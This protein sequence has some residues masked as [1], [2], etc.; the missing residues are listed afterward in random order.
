MT[1]PVPPE[2]PLLERLRGAVLALCAP[3][4]DGRRTGAAGGAAACDLLETELAR[5]GLEPAGEQGYRQRVPGCGG[6]NLL[7]R[8]PGSGPLSE[9]AVLVG[10]HYDHLGS[11]G[12]DVYHGADDNA[13]AVAITL[14]LGRALRARPPAGR[15]V[16]LALFD[17]EEPPHFTSQSM[18]S[19]HFCAQPTVPLGQVDL[20]VCMDLVGHA[21]GGPDLP[22]PVR[23]SL[24]VLGAELS[25]GTAALVERVA[26]RAR[27]VFPRRLHADVIP[28]LSDYYA[29][30]R[31]E[32]PFVFLSCGRWE[33]YHQPTDTPDRLDWDKL[34]ATGAFLEDL[35]REAAARPEPRVR[36][37]R[38]AR[39]DLA[40]LRSLLDVGRLL[41]P[42]HPQLAGLLPG[43]ES[44]A[45]RA[46]RGPLSVP[47]RQQL[48]I[49]VGSLEH[50]LR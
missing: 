45:A 35:V 2:P 7:A 17:A 43:V 23:R 5:L 30:W 40:S 29:F 3:D 24:F 26:G 48:S 41:L 31:R 14:E 34:A 21:C 28:P 19:M 13:A 38:D 37:E 16:I 42:T 18:G 8:I 15:Q 47:Q 4:L 11:D 46:A 33:H 12:A 49:L 9:R 6:T 20:M 50:L 27:G 22:D 1:E 25:Q 32:V 10:A 44:L 36:F 39:D